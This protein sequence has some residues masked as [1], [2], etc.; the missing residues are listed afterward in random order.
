[1]IGWLMRNKR[2][3][4]RKETPLITLRRSNMYVDKYKKITMNYSVT[5]FCWQ[6]PRP[7]RSAIRNTNT[8][9][10]SSSFQF[11]IVSLILSVPTDNWQRYVILNDLSAEWRSE[12]SG[13]RLVTC[14]YDIYFNIWNIC[15]FYWCIKWL[16][17]SPICCKNTIQSTWLKIG[18]FTERSK[19]L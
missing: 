3:R 11:I 6:S 18:F 8:N 19:S 9:C 2:I 1:M 7:F 14:L 16:W 4:I 13:W 10:S 5:E 17:P 12:D 15:H